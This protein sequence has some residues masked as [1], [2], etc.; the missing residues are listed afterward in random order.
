MSV[1]ILDE[2]WM[3]RRRQA[4]YWQARMDSDYLYG[5]GTLRRPV[6]AETLRE[7][8]AKGKID[9]ATF[10]RRLERLLGCT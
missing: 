6:T 8:Y 10:E 9:F 1:P 2:A 7:D 3:E 5:W 4:R